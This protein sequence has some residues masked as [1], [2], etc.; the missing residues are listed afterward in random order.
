MRGWTKAASA[1]L[2]LTGGAATAEAGCTRSVINRT[3]Y[4]VSFSQDGGPAVAVSPRHSRPIRYDASGSVSVSVY[5]PTGAGLHADMAAA[6]V[7]TER[8]HTV[9]VL[10]RCYVDIDGGGTQPVALNNPRQGDVAVAPYGV[11]C[12]LPPRGNTISARY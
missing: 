12:P 10:D 2:A 1:V 9:A 7:F 11:A 6:P 4:L 5:C 8:Y 3:P